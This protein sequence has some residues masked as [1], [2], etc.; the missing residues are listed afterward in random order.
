MEILL[1]NVLEEV[2]RV[3]ENTMQRAIFSF[4]GFRTFVLFRLFNFSSNIF[5]AI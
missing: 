1:G 4:F 5:L 3:V 2:D